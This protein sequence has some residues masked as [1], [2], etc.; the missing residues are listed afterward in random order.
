M[1]ELDLETFNLVLYLIFVAAAPLVV[2]TTIVAVKL[3]IGRI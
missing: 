1:Y 3:I 2:G